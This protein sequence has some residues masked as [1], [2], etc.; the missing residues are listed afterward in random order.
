MLNRSG[1]FV[2]VLLLA[3]PL[4]AQESSLPVLVEKN[5]TVR[6]SLDELMAGFRRLEDFHRGLK[7]IERTIF[8]PGA[9]RND[10]SL[11]L[12]NAEGKD[13][14]ITV[15][16]T[17]HEENGSK[18]IALKLGDKIL[19][20]SSPAMRK[21]ADDRGQGSSMPL[22]DCAVFPLQRIGLMFYGDRRLSR[23]FDVS[24]E[25][26]SLQWS[27][28]TAIVRY[29]TNEGLIRSEIHL[30]A[31][32]D[33]LWGPVQYQRVSR[34]AGQVLELEWRLENFTSA[35]KWMDPGFC[36]KG[37]FRQRSLRGEKE[38]FAEECRFEVV[39]RES[40]K[41]YDV[42]HNYSFVPQP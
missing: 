32:A 8:S 35:V 18:V 24:A 19:D 2:A 31:D 40:L 37:L 16:T 13:F 38:L 5:V 21:R 12:E 42:W 11:G 9:N 15:E 6:P 3:I 30:K 25:L 1:I 41:V 39:S 14:V 23:Y 4:N 29:S 28:E 20:P 36:A 27:E 26:F 7:V 10:V 22:C 34:S 17:L 33:G